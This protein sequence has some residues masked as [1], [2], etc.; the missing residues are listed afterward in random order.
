MQLSVI[1]TL[2]ETVRQSTVYNTRV[3]EVVAGATNSK[4]LKE[5]DKKKFENISQ[6][7]KLADLAFI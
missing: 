4:G 1:K 5:V 3:N 6:A 2:I 7:F